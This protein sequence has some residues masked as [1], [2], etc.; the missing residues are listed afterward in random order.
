MSKELEALET[1]KSFQNKR[2]FD[3]TYDNGTQKHFETKTIGELFP[4]EINKIENSLKALE[5]IKD[6][7]IDI[8][9][10][11]NHKKAKTYN[12]HT[13]RTF[14]EDYTEE[15]FELLKEILK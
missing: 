4:N 14:V 13:K 6:K 7:G 11:R 1:I 5:I 10:F 12:E 15:E 8:L 2:M 3:V 9:E